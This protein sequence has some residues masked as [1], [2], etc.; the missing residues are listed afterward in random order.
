MTMD[1]QRT[2][3]YFSMEIGLDPEMP[4]YSG[5]LGIPAGDTVRSAADI[6]VP[7]MELGKMMTSGVDLWLNTPQHPLEASGT[8]GMKAS[9]QHSRIT[10]I[11]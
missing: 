1:D 9:S 7:M 11:C 10:G 3:A 4:T 8:S 2:I 5:G 6:K